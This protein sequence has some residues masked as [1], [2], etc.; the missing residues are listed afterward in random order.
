MKLWKLKYIVEDKI[1]ELKDKFTGP[2]GMLVFRV[3]GVA[4]IIWLVFKVVTQ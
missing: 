1:E 4:I 3:L 2:N